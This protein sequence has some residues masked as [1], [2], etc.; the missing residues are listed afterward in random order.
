MLKVPHNIYFDLESLL[1]SYTSSQNNPN[2]SYTEKK[3]V[4]KPCSFSISLVRTHDKNISVK[5]RGKNCMKKFCK[6]LKKMAMKIIN[7]PQKPMIPLTD[8]EKRIS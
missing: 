5:Y 8:E 2:I 7:T 1:V 3:Y 6:A 4:H